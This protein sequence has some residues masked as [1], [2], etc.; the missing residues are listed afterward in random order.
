M[1]GRT[2]GRRTL[3]LRRWAA[4]CLT[5]ALVAVGATARA[6]EEADGLLP[7][8]G[9]GAYQITLETFGEDGRPLFKT[10]GRLGIEAMG[11]GRW[12][13]RLYSAE[14]YD[15]RADDWNALLIDSVD[16]RTD[17]LPE[18]VEVEFVVDGPPD[19]QHLYPHDIPSVAFGLLM[20]TSTM[21]SLCSER[22]GFDALR[23]PGDGADIEPFSTVWSRP[24]GSPETRRTL[25]GGTTVFEGV[26][27][28]VASVTLETDG[29]HWAM[30][31]GYAPP[32]RLS[33]GGEE[34]RL[35]VELDAERG[36]L[37]RVVA[38]SVFRITPLG[39]IE[40]DSLPARESIEFPDD[41]QTFVTRRT[42]EL[43][44][45]TPEEAEEAETAE[46]GGE[47]SQD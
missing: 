25:L 31:N 37:L 47:E 16:P 27:D 39:E 2:R 26:E 44:R 23:A 43:R 18:G 24:Y 29:F 13:V 9:G 35:L 34:Y 10:R 41:A 7:E 33:A 15:Q 20:E 30:L 1:T 42:I 19:F 28:G 3:A 5:T 32:L 4:A 11:E 22:A 45:L 17:D 38:E 14:R 6:G 21:L 46:G 40:G 36:S 8:S 12:R